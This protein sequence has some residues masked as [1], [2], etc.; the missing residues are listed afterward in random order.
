MRRMYSHLPEIQFF[1]VT[2]HFDTF[3]FKVNVVGHELKHHTYLFYGRFET[4]F[5]EKG[6]G[7]VLGKSKYYFW[8][9]LRNTVF[10]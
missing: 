9:D 10:I 2:I 1:H 7:I 6:R 8:S 4:T 5:M 3:V